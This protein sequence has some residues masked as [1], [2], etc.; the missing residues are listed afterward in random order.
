[1]RGSVLLV[2]FA[3]FAIVARVIFFVSFVIFI[4]A[5]FTPASLSHF[6]CLPSG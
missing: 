3:L 2:T 4:D 1:V 5:S 6:S